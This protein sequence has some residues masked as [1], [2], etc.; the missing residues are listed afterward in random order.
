MAS[1]RW[2]ARWL[3]LVAGLI[4]ALSQPPISWPWMLIIALPLMFRLW[5]LAA[6]NARAFWVGWFAGLGYFGATLHWIVEPFLVQPEIFGWMIPFALVGMAGGMALFWGAGFW[7]AKRIG[8]AGWGAPFAL[9]FGLVGMEWLRGNILSGFPWSLLGYAWVESYA[10]QLASF[11][12]IYGV[13]LWTVLVGAMLGYLLTVRTV[14]RQLAVSASILLLFFGPYLYS[15]DRQVF[16][17]I[18]ESKDLTPDETAPQ[19]GLVQPNVAQRDKWQPHLREQHLNDLLTKTRDLSDRGAD[20]VIWP[21]AATPYQFDTAPQLRAM[22]AD[23]LKPGGVLLAG[24]IRF[25]DGRTFNSLIAVDSTGTILDTY[26]KQHLVPFGEKMPLEPLL[27][28]I[29]LRAMISL[30]GGFSS[31][32]DRERSMTIGDLPPLVPMICYEAI[33]PA[34]I[35]RRAAKGDWLVQVTNDAWFGNWVGPYQHLAMARVRAIERGLPVAR[36]A[37]TG[38]SAMIDGYGRQLASLPLNEAGVVLHA[39][40]RRTAATLY[41]RYEDIPFGIGL[42]LC[43][44]LGIVGRRR[45]E[46]CSKGREK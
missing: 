41:S 19:I 37:N 6:G 1:S 28:R 12:G 3:A 23:A 44:G 15:A 14:W 45:R 21:E 2:G 9:T 31:G 20:V 22:I 5:D 16:V 40:P 7:V 43:L 26:D 33:F 29:G 25:E 42:F 17:E 18:T 30:P 39:L 11:V 34:E 27:S 36:A 35:M 4:A 38:V 32:K 10:I 46:A 8:S 24:G 13:T